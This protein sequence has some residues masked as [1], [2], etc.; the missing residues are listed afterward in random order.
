MP[1]HSETKSKINLSNLDKNLALYI[2]GGRAITLSYSAL[3]LLEK[4]RISEIG[5][6]IRLMVETVS[7]AEYFYDS[8]ENDKNIIKWFKNEIISPKKVRKAKSNIF[9]K[10]FGK[11]DKT[12]E[13]IIN[14][15]YGGMSEY[16]HPTYGISKLN[17]N[18]VTLEYDYEYIDFKVLWP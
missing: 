7:L 2:L 16:I 17:L 10:V 9:K 6:V 3:L 13:K 15:L 11:T 8:N 18:I 5:A 14:D 1:I 12:I 4:C